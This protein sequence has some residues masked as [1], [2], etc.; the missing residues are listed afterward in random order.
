MQLD[1][2]SGGLATGAVSPFREM[3]AYE[4]LW[5]RPGTTFRSLAARFG[6]PGWPLDVR[7]LLV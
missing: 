3:G 7:E 5:L 2:G 1:L 6:R 4:A